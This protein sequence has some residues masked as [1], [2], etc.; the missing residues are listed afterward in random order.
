[1]GVELGVR[2][3]GEIDDNV[4]WKG[5]GNDAG[6][7]KNDRREWHRVCE[8]FGDRGCVGLHGGEAVG[9]VRSGDGGER[10]GVEKMGV[11]GG[12]LVCN[13]PS[14]CGS[15]RFDRFGGGDESE[16]GANGA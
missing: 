2:L 7:D 10:G 8:R 4:V 12:M 3:G 16:L 5:I 1:M 6:R 13:F 9:A 15:N 14:E 11:Y